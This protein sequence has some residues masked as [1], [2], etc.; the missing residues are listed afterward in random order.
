MKFTETPLRVLYFNIQWL[1]TS[2]KFTVKLSI[3]QD[4]DQTMDIR[5]VQTNVYLFLLTNDRNTWLTTVISTFQQISSCFNSTNKSELTP[6]LVFLASRSAVQVTV[7][8]DR[9]IVPQSSVLVLLS[10]EFHHVRR[11]LFAIQFTLH[12]LFALDIL[13]SPYRSF[14]ASF[15]AIL[16]RLL[17][18]YF[19]KFRRIIITICCF[20]HVLRCFPYGCTV[21]YM[22][23]QK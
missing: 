19:H 21:Q 13:T 17:W 20:L 14:T 1:G 10:S 2:R 9:R 16:V 3:V 4:Y 22:K 5:S 15:V 18:K 23:T 11:T 8:L 6:S 12:V 7:M